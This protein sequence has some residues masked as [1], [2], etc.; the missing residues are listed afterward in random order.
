MFFVL[1]VGSRA[2]SGQAAGIAPGI[3]GEAERNGVGF[4]IFCWVAADRETIRI[5]L[6]FVN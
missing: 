1:H 2:R 4:G 5:R 3:G 6:R